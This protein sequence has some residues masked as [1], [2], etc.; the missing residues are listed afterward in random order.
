MDWRGRGARRADGS[1][2]RADGRSAGGQVAFQKQQQLTPQQQ[3]VEADS[4]IARMEQ[5]S[6][7][8]RR[9]L[10][11]ARAARDVVK[12]LC[13]NDKLSQIDV[14]TRSAK[15][16]RQSLQ[17]AH[18]SKR[19]GARQPRVHD[20]HGSCASAP[21]SSPPKP[22]SASA[23]RPRSSVNRKSPRPSIR[24]FRRTTTRT[25]TAPI[26]TSSSIPRVALPARIR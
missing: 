26:R 3:I 18:R 17:L 10:E 6:G 13:L 16:R 9:Q 25:T 11:A 2:A 19:R 24:R 23:K 5:A 21:S 4:Q 7:N 8:V 15:D 22:T 14:A 12:T 1:C 20:S